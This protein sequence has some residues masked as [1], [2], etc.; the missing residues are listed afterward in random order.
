MQTGT[1]NLAQRSC[2][3]RARVDL[4]ETLVQG[5][6]KFRFDSRISFSRRE[7]GNLILKRRQLFDISER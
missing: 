3:D 7:R 5:L 1:I 6:P 4:R 2:R